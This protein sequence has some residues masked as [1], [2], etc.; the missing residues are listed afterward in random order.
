MYNRDSRKRK[1]DWK[2][3]RC[4]AAE[5]NPTSNHEDA[6]SIHG[7][8]QGV[9]D[10]HCYELWHR[11]A[12]VALI[13]LLAWEPPY[14]VGTALKSKKKKKNTRK[15]SRILS[16]CSRLMIWH[17]R[18]SSWGSIPGPRNFHMPLAWPKQTN[19][20]KKVLQFSDSWSIWIS[21]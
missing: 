13:H 1:A 9:K 3:S 4:G 10:Q 7:L 18:C 15:F 12:A 19:K 14:A 2:S 5:K 11:L 17:C 8:T 6:G 21:S 16:W 20:Q